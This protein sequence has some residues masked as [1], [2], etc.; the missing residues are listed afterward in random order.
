MSNGSRQSDSFYII[1]IFED[2]DA[3]TG[4]GGRSDRGVVGSERWIS[5]VCCCTTV[6]EVY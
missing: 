2:P 4:G 5:L 6:V 3:R 1:C